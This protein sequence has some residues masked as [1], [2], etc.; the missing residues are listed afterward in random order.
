LPW[1][2]FIIAAAGVAGI[3][4]V[5]LV[6]MLSAP[7]VFLAMARDG[8]VPAHFFGDV[9]PK[10]RT[11][12]KSTILVGVFVATMTGFLPIDALLHLTNIG[13]LFAFVLVALGVIVL[14]RTRPDLPRSFTTPWVP[15]L[16][17][18]SVLASIYLMLN[19]PALTWVRFVIWM[20]IGLVVYFLYGVRRSRL[21]TGGADV[22]RAVRGRP[23]VLDVRDLE[24][25]EA[26][27]R[28][29]RR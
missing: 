15:V 10:F 5:L 16:P 11:P 22:T 13:T 29:R 24:E 4:S 25:R 23:E 2:D 9:H 18:V 1:A 20:A 21:A 28:E 26:R 17:I 6:L 3:T 19:L 12:W 27:R 7:R 14:R 8:M